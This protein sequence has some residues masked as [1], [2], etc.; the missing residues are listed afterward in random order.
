MTGTHTKKHKT[1]GVAM[2]GGVDST[3]TAALLIEQGHRVHGFFMLLPLDGLEQ[4]VRR[5]RDVADRLSVPL[6]L[7]D[8]RT[9]FEREIIGYF[10]DSYRH[11]LTPNPCVVCNRSI[12]FGRLLEEM[13][14]QGMEQVAT[15]HYAG[16]VHHRGRPLLRRAVDRNKDQSYFLG[17][18]SRRQLAQLVLPLDG[19]EKRRVFALARELGF[20]QFNGTE[21]QDVCFLANGPLRDFLHSRGLTEQ[22]G[23]IVSSSGRVLGSH[24]G[25]WK[26]TVGQ[27]RGLG[28]PD[29]TP[30]YVTG[31][32]PEHNRVIIGKNEDLLHRHVLLDQVLWHI[33]RPDSWQGMVQLRSRHRAAAAEVIPRGSDRWLV[34]FCTPQ[35]AITPGQF[36]VFY[37]NDLLVGSGCIRGPVTG[38]EEQ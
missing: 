13:R 9:T 17:R 27:R 29:T 25:I 12:K 15:G 24:Q 4:Q 30:W 5:V 14:E 6:H 10:I 8:L 3:V 21:S 36:A 31:L 20:G 32:D 19:L 1:I 37:D 2:S 18:L 16:L 22:R 7:V 34:S 28:I 11:G 38:G 35:R 33:P 23:D 26:Y